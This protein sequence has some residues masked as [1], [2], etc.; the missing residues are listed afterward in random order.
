MKNSYPVILTPDKVG[1]TVYIPDLESNTE[2][3]TLTEAI[4]MTRDAVGLLGITLEDMGKEIPKPSD[5]KSIKHAEN[6]ST[7]I[8]MIIGEKTI[9]AP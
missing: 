7:S 8:L 5:I 2:G 3:D 6:E 1:Y 9:C 4:E